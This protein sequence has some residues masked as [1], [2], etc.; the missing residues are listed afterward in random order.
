MGLFAAIT[1]NLK[2]RSSWVIWVGPKFSDKYSYKGYEQMIHTWR[3][4]PPE[5]GGKDWSVV[6]TNQETPESS[7]GS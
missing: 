3:R 2:M 4:K 1:K 5:D 6:A 7:E